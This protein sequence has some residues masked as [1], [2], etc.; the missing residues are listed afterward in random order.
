MKARER[1]YEGRGYKKGPRH[2]STTATMDYSDDEMEFMS[3]IQGWKRQQRNEFP[4]WSDVLGVQKGLGYAKP[5][6]AV[7]TEGWSL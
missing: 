6:A 2:P 3:A 1:R 4:T 7:R 5:P